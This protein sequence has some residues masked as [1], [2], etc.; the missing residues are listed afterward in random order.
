MPRSFARSPDCDGIDD[1][2]H[3]LGVEV[4]DPFPS[5]TVPSAKIWRSIPNW[6]PL[7][8]RP[9]EIRVTSGSA[10]VTGLFTRGL[11]RSE[12]TAGGKEARQGDGGVLRA[13]WPM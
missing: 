6:V 10:S 11:A 8:D 7:S 9:S 12:E 13:G 5:M 3:H 4:M 2:L 1:R